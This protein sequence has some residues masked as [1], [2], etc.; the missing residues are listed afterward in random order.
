[1]TLKMSSTVIVEL[2]TFLW[3]N[4]N[5]HFYYCHIF[6]V[7]KSYFFTYECHVVFYGPYHLM[8]ESELWHIVIRI[9]MVLFCDI[10]CFMVFLQHDNNINTQSLW[11]YPQ[12]LMTAMRGMDSH[13]EG[14]CLRQMMGMSVSTGT[15][16]SFWIKELFL[17]W[18]LHL[19]K[20]WDRITSAG[21][22]H[23]GTKSLGLTY[24]IIDLEVVHSLYVKTF[25]IFWILNL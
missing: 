12:A 3:L 25:C 22:K 19:M 5:L 21:Y 1:M 4:L 16:S 9:S 14:R 20:A 7:Y 10:F 24:L 18:H 23:V 15:L 6:Q 8:Y 17:Q 11:L 2:I 13:T